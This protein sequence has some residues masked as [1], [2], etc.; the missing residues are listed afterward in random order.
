MSKSAALLLI[1]ILTA[2]GLVMVKPAR[3]LASI[4]KPSVPEFTVKLVDHSYD[5]PTTYSIDA[6]T[7][8]NVTHA[9]YHVENKTIEV[10]IKNQP[11]T[12]YWVME[13][14]AN[15]TVY[16]YYNVRVKGNYA[17]NWTTLY[18]GGRHD[19]P[20]ASNSDYTTI[21][22]LLTLSLTHPEQGYT[23][24]YYDFST[25][26]YTSRLSGLPSNAQLDFQV[27]ALIGYVHRGYNPNTTDPVQ[28]WPWIFTGETS[29]WSSTQTITLPTSTPSPTSSPSPTSTPDQTPEPTP[30]ETPQ[31]LQLEAIIGTVIAVVLVG[32][33]LL[34]YFKKRKR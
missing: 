14:T 11:F 16:F 9:G 5:V 31:T 26:S 2:S 15:W 8:E 21:T 34:L 12:S 6:Y 13:G 27:Q 24:E 20:T 29:D 4:S 18:S 19:F 30:K 25:N 33:G 17:E 10:T 28:M 22:C 1:L 23:L 32:A 3:V 7:G